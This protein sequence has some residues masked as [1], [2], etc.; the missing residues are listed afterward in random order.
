MAY[1]PDPL[2]IH[3]PL[4]PLDVPDIEPNP[5]VVAR[6]ENYPKS[7]GVKETLAAKQAYVDYVALGPGRTF[8][9]LADLYQALP[10]EDADKAPTQSAATI[11]MWADKW[12]WEKRVAK[13]LDREL[14]DIERMDKE[15]RRD[16]LEKGYALM[17]ERVRGLKALAGDIEEKLL[18][19]RLS[20]RDLAALIGQLRGVLDDIAKEQG[21]RKPI[22]EASTD[23]KPVF[24]IN[25]NIPT[26]E[27]ME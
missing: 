23:S 27:W 5:D 24:V 11:R 6:W 16:V 9:G 21:Q 22:I 3:T 7:Y 26:P 1:D 4:S 25:N 17:I 18:D 19:D 14:K 10:P 8:K 2:D 15:Y 20:A 13:I 12:Q